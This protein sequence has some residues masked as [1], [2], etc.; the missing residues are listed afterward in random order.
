MSESG[1]LNR[2]NLVSG[3]SS[4]ASAFSFIARSAS[5]YRCVVFG[6]SCPSHSAMTLNGTPDCS[7]CIAVVWRKDMRRNPLLGEG[8]QL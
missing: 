1:A 5:T 3:A 2:R 8:G 7:R 6:L 4:R